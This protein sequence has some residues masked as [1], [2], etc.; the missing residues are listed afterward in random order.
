MSSY[1]VVYSTALR[2]SKLMMLYYCFVYPILGYQTK[3][4]IFL[5]SIVFP[6]WFT[7]LLYLLTYYLYLMNLIGL[8]N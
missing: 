5:S 7:D 3:Q 4:N 2:P 1:L 6:Y 8:Q